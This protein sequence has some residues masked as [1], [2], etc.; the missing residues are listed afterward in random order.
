MAYFEVYQ[1]LLGNMRLSVLIVWCWQRQ[2]CWHQMN[3]N[4]QAFTSSLGQRKLE[5]VFI[6]GYLLVLVVHFGPEH[7]L[8][9]L[10]TG[11]LHIFERPLCLDKR[12][13]GEVNCKGLIIL[14]VNCSE[15]NEVLAS[16]TLESCCIQLKDRS[17]EL[18][19]EIKLLAVPIRISDYKS[20]LPTNL[21]E[22]GPLLEILAVTFQLY[23]EF[24]MSPWNEVE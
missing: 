1:Y 18:A 11:E 2:G 19:N 6:V 9:R 10:F 17:V 7:R 22:Q 13:I 4:G 21:V 15:F 14:C 23:L 8:E 3:R 20:T 24:N 16:L 12:N 5:T